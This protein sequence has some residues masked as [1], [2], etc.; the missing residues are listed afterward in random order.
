[1][2][3]RLLALCAAGALATPA[4]AADF[5]QTLFSYR[6]GD[7]FSEPARPND[8]HKEI[9]TLTQ[10]MGDRWGNHLFCLEARFSDRND[11][12]KD[13]GGATEYLFNYRWLLTAERATGQAVAFGPVRDL[14]FLAGVDLT[15]KDTLFA[16]R[17]RAWMAG[18]AIRFDVPG[19]L[20]V[21]LLVYEE[22]NHKGI[23]GTPHPDITFEPTWM[24]NAT[25]R[26]PLQIGP[27]GSIFQGLFNRIGEKG[28]DFN[29]RPTAGETLLRTNLLFDVGQPLGA[30][31][32]RVLAG[33]G[34][35]W[36]HNKYGSR[37]GVGTQTRT[38]TLN[39]EIGF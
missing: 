5:S 24:L 38:P 27:A 16:P 34:Y 22:S 19:F 10:A 21:G 11:P 7:S 20:D 18:P 3:T 15:T 17:K 2:K 14:G 39:L 1:M 36:W 32:N 35:E 12:A 33:V 29:D 23:P 31:K 26:I 6:Q 9:L 25:W 13:G 30:G 4:V 37:P 28:R 8:I